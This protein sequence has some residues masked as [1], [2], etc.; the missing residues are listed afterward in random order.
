MA[1]ATSCRIWLAMA[2]V[3]VATPEASGFMAMPRTSCDKASA[4]ASGI[5]APRKVRALVLSP[6]SRARSVGTRL[7]GIRMSGAK[8]GDKVTVHYVGTQEDGSEFDSSRTRNR[9]C[10]ES[11]RLD[12]V[13]ACFR[14]HARV[15]DETRVNVCVCLCNSSFDCTNQSALWTHL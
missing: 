9:K 14:A 12:D 15:N 6:M 10:K 2:I 13:A 1:T 5:C 4:V 8:A 11:I 3:L 7:P